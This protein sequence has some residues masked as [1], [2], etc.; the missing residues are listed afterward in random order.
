M[1]VLGNA[2]LVVILEVEFRLIFVIVENK[3]LPTPKAVSLP[4][5]AGPF[6]ER[7]GA[8]VVIVVLLCVTQGLVILALSQEKMRNVF[9]DRNPGVRSVEI[10]DSVGNVGKCAKNCCLAGGIGATNCVTKGIVPLVSEK[11]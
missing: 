4:I 10:R 6:V 9:V 2:L 7:N 5:L 1:D 8:L 3:H 11:S